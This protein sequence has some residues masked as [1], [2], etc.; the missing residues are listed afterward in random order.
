MSEE[1]KPNSASKRVVVAMSGGVDS[2]VAAA[3]LKMQGYEV[4]GV[5]L[6]LWDYKKNETKTNF[7]PEGNCDE[8]NSCCSPIDVNDARKVADTLDIPFYVINAEEEFKT[9]VVDYFVNEYVHA[10]TPNPCAMCNEFIKFDLLLKRAKEIGAS[11]LATGHY[12]KVVHDVDSDSYELHRGI[13]ASKDQ[14]YYLFGLKQR[15]LRDLLMPLGEM[16]KD[17]VRKIASK[18]GL[19]TAMK[20]DSYEVCFVGN[21]SYSNF[22]KKHAP[23]EFQTGGLILTEKGETVGRHEGLFNYTIGQ[24][25]GLNLS[26]QKSEAFYVTRMEPHSSTLYVGSEEQI[27]QDRLL[28]SQMNWVG[29]LDLSKPLQCEAKIRSRHEEVEATVT[30]L[31][32]NL[33]EVQFKEKQRAITPGQA[34]VLYQGTRVIGGGWIERVVEPNLDFSIP[35]KKSVTASPEGKGGEAPSKEG[36]PS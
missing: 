5:N 28:S 32:G 15:Q 17:H 14:T 7:N 31:P 29:G 18:F 24:R 20:K 1:K 6:Q 16:R 22:V 13:D 4:I 9:A 8:F 34:I 2:S 10:R 3:L 21:D 19:P 25:K 12:A 30:A 36:S 27:F 23:K 11:K 26:V 33:A 35:L